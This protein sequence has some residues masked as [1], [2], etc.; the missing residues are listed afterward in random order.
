MNRSGAIEVLMPAVQPAELWQESGRWGYYGRELLRFRDRH[1]R[2]GCIG[3]THEEVITDLVRKEVHSYKQMPINL[4]QINEKFRD[5]FR[6]PEGVPLGAWGDAWASGSDGEAYFTSRGLRC[7]PPDRDWGEIWLNAKRSYQGDAR[8]NVSTDALRVSVAIDTFLVRRTRP[9]PEAAFKIAFLPE[10]RGDTIWGYAADALYLELRYDSS[11][12][13]LTFL[14]FRHRGADGA[15]TLLGEETRPFET[16]GT[17]SLTLGAEKME[18]AYEAEPV[19]ERAHGL[20][21]A[22]AFPEGVWI[23]LEAQ[24]GDNGSRAST[25]L[26]AVDIETVSPGPSFVRGDVNSDGEIDIG[27]P[28][29]LLAY[30]FASGPLT[31][32]DAGD[33]NDD[34]EYSSDERV[35]PEGQA[36][37]TTIRGSDGKR[38]GTS[39]G[40][41]ERT[42]EEAGPIRA[43][44]KTV[45]HAVSEDGSRSLR[46]EKRIVAW[47]G[48][49]LLRVQHTFVNDLAPEFTN[50]EE[51]SFDVPIAAETWRA[52]RVNGNAI[53][54]DGEVKSVW[55]RTDRQSVVQ[56]KSGEVV[57]DARLTGTLF[58][59]GANGCAI[60]MR[61]AW[62]QYPKGFTGGGGRVRVGLCPDFEAGFYDKFPFEKEGHHLY[63]Y[64][65]DGRYRFKRGMAKTHDLLLYFGPESE[66]VAAC[67]AFQRPPLA[68]APP[69]WYC[70][71]KAFYAVFIFGEEVDHITEM[72]FER[73]GQR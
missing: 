44:I 8:F 24:N 15:R 57:M 63:Y 40:K 72:I 54:L 59:E 27:D 29:G 10:Y 2:D 65:R 48:A 53:T 14:L 71:S 12:R 16:G 41:A 46:I 66:R 6:G 30:L 69:K 45:G 17:V 1:N 67:K 31:C 13:L 34:G 64:L 3:P 37:D 22:A 28:I 33:A 32:L 55:Q 19:L 36:C 11:S 42:I 25:I 38:Y 58:S 51:L 50:I 73:V 39:L 70:D 5:E 60:V 18:A 56:S 49:P 62:Q 47:V 20:D 61:D 68:T 9:G 21:L 43:V 23:H 26:R 52:E 4:Y 7:D 35:F